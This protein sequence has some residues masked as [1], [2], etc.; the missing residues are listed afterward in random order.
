MQ[1]IAPPMSV[2]GLILFLLGMATLTPEI[3]MSGI[4]VMFTSAGLQLKALE[5]ERLE[6]AAPNYP[7]PEEAYHSW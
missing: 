4:M 6:E 2:T 1:K 3:Y 5:A 7:P